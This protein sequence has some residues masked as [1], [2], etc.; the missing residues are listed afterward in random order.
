MLIE[1]RLDLGDE[2][3]AIGA[4]ESSRKVR[5]DKRIGIE[6]SERL[7]VH[8]TPTAQQQPRGAELILGGHPQGL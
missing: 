6:R 3:I 1:S 2:L 4:G 5:H 7:V 8:L